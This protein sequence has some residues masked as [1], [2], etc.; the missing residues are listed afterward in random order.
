MNEPTKKAGFAKNSRG[1]HI[2]H[3]HH[4]HSVAAHFCKL[5]PRHFQVKPG[6]EDAHEELTAKET[7]CVPAYPFQERKCNKKRVKQ[8]EKPRNASRTRQ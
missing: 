6:N 3:V 8:G 7:Y 4:E 5:G 1:A 2:H